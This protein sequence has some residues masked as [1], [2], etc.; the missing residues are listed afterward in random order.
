MGRNLAILCV[1]ATGGLV[2]LQPPANAA[3]AEHVGDFGAA[4]L[5]TVISVTTIAV[6]FFVFGHPGRLGGLSHFR[7]EW[8]IGGLGGAAVVTIGLIAVRPLGAGA[9]VALL[10]AAQLIASVISDRF[11]WFGAPQVALSAGRVAGLL[12]VVAGTVL[13]TRT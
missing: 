3:L 10:V 8:L 2:G 1:L 9:V 11:G 6:L 7:L 5:S 13:V 4:L 12:L